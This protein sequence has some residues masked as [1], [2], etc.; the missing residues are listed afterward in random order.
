IYVPDRS[1]G[2]FAIQARAGQ[3]PDP[4]LDGAALRAALDS[5][6]AAGPSTDQFEGAR[7]LYVPI[8]GVNEEFGLLGIEPDHPLEYSDPEKR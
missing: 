3:P 1:E 2:E 5:G 4:T 7:G 6:E 8:A